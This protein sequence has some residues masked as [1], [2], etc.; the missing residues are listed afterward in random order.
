MSKA[1]ELL[2][3]IEEIGYYGQHNDYSD[4]AYDRDTAEYH[5]PFSDLQLPDKDGP[6]LVAQTKRM[7]R[8]SKIENGQGNTVK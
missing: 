3:K 8:K 6:G 2:K 5:A 1:I 4:K 7:K